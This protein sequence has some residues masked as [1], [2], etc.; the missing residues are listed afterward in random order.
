MSSTS[1]V[2]NLLVNV[3]RPVYIY[4]VTTTLFTPKL[5]LSNIDNYSGNTISVFTAAIGDANSNVYVGSNA[6]NP[7]TTL[8]A[9]RNVTA[10]GVSAG[11]GISNVSNSVFFGYNAGAGASTA[12]NNV[13]VGDNTT[14]NGTSNVRIGSAS[15]G[16]GNN[17]TVIGA[18]TDTSGN[19]GTI[20]I[21]PNITATAN[22]Q[23]RVG[24]NY[25]YG[26]ISNKW[27]GVGTSSPYDV[28]DKMDISGNLYVLGQV[29]INIAPGGRTLDVNGNFRASDAFGTLDFS[30]GVTLSSGGLG[31]ITGTFIGSTPGTTTLGTLKKGTILVSA[32]DTATIA[33]YASVMVY[34]VDPTDGAANVLLSSNVQAGEISLVFS[35]SNIQ[36]SNVNTTRT[37]SWSVTYFPLP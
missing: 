11:A 2:Q 34:C 5:Q 1:G 7:Y 18:S 22:N 35:G 13:S 21:G 24:S 20:L 29:G 36:M 10:V 12:S 9:S 27:L 28:N 23:F 37:I 33:D 19:S 3:F 26:D 8:Q 4:D 15:V 31:S 32:Q 25:L 14:G 6:G 16:A 17:N 30:N